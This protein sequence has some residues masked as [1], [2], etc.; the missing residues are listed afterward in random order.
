LIRGKGD[1]VDVVEEHRPDGRILEAGD[2]S[3]QSRL[4]E[5]LSP[6]GSEEGEELALVNGQID[7]LESWKLGKYC[8]LE[9][10]SWEGKRYGSPRAA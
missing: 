5:T 9:G 6:T 8:L 7:A 1:D 2:D 3:K 4:A 10:G